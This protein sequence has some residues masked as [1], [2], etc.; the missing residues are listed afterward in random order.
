M[1]RQ[2]EELCGDPLFQLNMAIWLSQPKPGDFGVR[3]IFHESGFRV[4]SIGPRLSIPPDIRLILKESKIEYHESA[5]PD[6]VLASDN[7]SKICILE[8]KK[9]S[10]GASSSNT[11]QAKTLLIISGPTAPE[12]LGIGLRNQANGILVYMTRADQVDALQSTLNGLKIDLSRINIKTGEPGCFGLGCNEKALSIRYSGNIGEA[13]NINH[14]SPVEVLSLDDDTD[15]RPLYIIPYDPTLF[16]QH[17]QEEEKICRR[18]LYERFLGHVLCKVGSANAPVEIKIPIDEILNLSTFHFFEIWDDK[19]VRQNFKSLLK[20]FMMSLREYLGDGDILN[21]ES[22][23]GWIIKVKD[24]TTH[25]NI[26]KQI[27]KFRPEGM[28]LD[29]EIMPLLFED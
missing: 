20:E 5:A 2:I 14:D 21:F 24:S 22:G 16:N 10:F 8:C 4:F 17:S 29:E 11:L 15:P 26:I 18:I 23:L 9:N 12:I 3:P 7:Y 6:I 1:N 19:S 25:E 28:E 13:M 27:G